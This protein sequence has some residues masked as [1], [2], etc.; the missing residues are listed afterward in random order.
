VGVQERAPGVHGGALR[1]RRE[2]VRAQD[3]ANRCGGHAMTETTQFAL[4][5]RVPPGGVLMHEPDDQGRELPTLPSHQLRTSRRCQRISVP[6]VTS[7]IGAALREAAG[8]VQRAP[9][10]L[11]RPAAG[12]GEC[13]EARRLRGA[14]PGSRR[15]SP[16]ASGQAAPASSQ[17]MRTPDTAI[18]RTRADSIPGTSSSRP[19]T[20]SRAKG[21][22]S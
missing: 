10:G 15:L 8:S 19:R 3:L 21:L 20:R 22:V 16:L 7:G 12:D 6:G 5:P 1:G 14:T 2:P 13:G 9:P 18:G 11:P 4:D 17:A